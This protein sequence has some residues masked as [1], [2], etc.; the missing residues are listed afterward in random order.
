MIA[1][2]LIFAVLGRADF[3]IV[4]GMRIGSVSVGMTAE[5]LN[6]TLGTATTGDAAMGKAWA[7]WKSPNGNRLDV[8]TSQ[9]AVVLVR[10]TSPAFKDRRNF[11]TGLP[12]PRTSLF[13]RVAAY[14]K[15]GQRTLVFDDPKRGYGYE[16]T[17]DTVT[18]IFVHK[19]GVS[20]QGYIPL[21]QYIAGS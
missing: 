1:S 16:V 20:V 12:A 8:Y 6:R 7:T 5:A 10:V 17:G 9:Q 18:A 4:P 11:R 14:E 3:L 19:P 2:T 21:T 15:S 13:T